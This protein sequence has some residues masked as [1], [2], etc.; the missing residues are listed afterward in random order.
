MKK[1]A[2]QLLATGI[3][4]LASAFVLMGSYAFVNKPKMPKELRK[5]LLRCE[6]CLAS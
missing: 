2:Y 6:K 1:Q 3:I 4:A 5:Q